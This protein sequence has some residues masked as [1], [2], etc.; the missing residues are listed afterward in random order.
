MSYIDTYNKDINVIRT[1]QSAKVLINGI[2]TI[3]RLV[4][5]KKFNLSYATLLKSEVIHNGFNNHSVVVFADIPIDEIDVWQISG[6]VQ[7]KIINVVVEH[8]FHTHEQNRSGSGE[9]TIN[10][11]DSSLKVEYGGVSLA[12]IY[13]E[14]GLYKQ[15]YEKALSLGRYKNDK[16]DKLVS[17]A[18]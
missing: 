12:D 7:D 18:H 2:E 11:K 9:T 15:C 16:S 8:V 1:A 17:I 3:E 6:T 10:G 14:S 4:K 13:Q 5:P